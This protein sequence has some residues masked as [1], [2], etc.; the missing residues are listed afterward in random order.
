MQ[1]NRLETNPHQLSSIDKL[2]PRP[3]VD[4]TSDGNVEVHV[5]VSDR[6]ILHSSGGA[7]SSLKEAAQIKYRKYSRWSG[8]VC[9]LFLIETLTNGFLKA[10]L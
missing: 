9:T 8:R 4:K 10:D 5:D 7:T 1:Y 6:N 3:T 2:S